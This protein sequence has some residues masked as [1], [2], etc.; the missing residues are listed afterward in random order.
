MKD[1]DYARN[2]IRMRRNEISTNKKNHLFLFVYRF[3]LLSM[4]CTVLLLTYMINEKIVLVKIPKNLNFDNIQKM[5]P[6]EN[7]F[8]FQND[9][10]STYPTYS[11]LKGNYYTNGSNQSYAVLNGVVLQVETSTEH[12]IMVRIQHDNGVMGIYQNLN[13]C[14]VKQ[15]E[16]V[17]EGDILGTYSDS[18]LMFFSKNNKD[19]TLEEVLKID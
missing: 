15:D 1:I 19:L 5:I 7:W 17:M 8:S 6:F 18:I 10:V 12:K 9:K 11:L 4:F 3:M 2:R 16:R 14:H 13:E